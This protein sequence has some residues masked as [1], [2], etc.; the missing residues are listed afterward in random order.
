M[1]L[2]DGHNANFTANNERAIVNEPNH[3]Y[4]GKCGRI[5]DTDE[6]AG[7]GC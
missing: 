1:L 6:A 7:V 2:F 4:F 3:P 5:I